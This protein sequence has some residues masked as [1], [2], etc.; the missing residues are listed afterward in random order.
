MLLV[1]NPLYFMVG[2]GLSNLF[3]LYNSFYVEEY[4]L[5][6][7]IK[8]FYPV[9]FQSCFVVFMLSEN[10]L[11]LIM[12]TFFC[13]SVFLIGS[14]HY[15][16]ETAAAF[17]AFTYSFLKNTCRASNKISDS[18]QGHKAKKKDG[19]CRSKQRHDKVWRGQPNK[20]GVSHS[21]KGI[22]I[23]QVISKI[24]E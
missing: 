6:S 3:A 16:L 13:L 20:S 8:G 11:V 14:M 19:H 17:L 7:I 21:P 22:D 9:L 18:T 1:E 15:L 2:I 5:L 4:R 23:K 10:N 24:N 12:T